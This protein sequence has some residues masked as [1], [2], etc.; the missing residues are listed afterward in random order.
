MLN[1]LIKMGY[2]EKEAKIYLAS[3]ELGQATVQEIAKKAGV[4]RPTAYFV[5]EGLIKDGLLSSF[6][7]AKKQ[8]FTAAEP[9]RLLDILEREK[10]NIQEKN[11]TLIKLLPELQSLYKKGGKPVV[12]YYEGKEGIATMVREFLEAAKGTVRMVY[13]YDS[14]SKLFEKLERERWQNTRLKKNV[15]TKVLYTRKEGELESTPLSERRKIPYEKFP[16]ACDIAIY[17]DKIR[18]ASLKER[19]SGIIIEDKELAEAMKAIFE[20]A[21]ETTEKH[22]TKKKQK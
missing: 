3:L 18:M 5:I 20:M 22:D 14:V 6:H 13:S 16:V 1:E 19:L 9:A 7:K 10:D 21:W 4:N 2:S 8:Y 17:N 11:Q 15:K 12:R